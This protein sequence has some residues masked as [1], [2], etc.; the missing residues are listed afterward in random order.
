MV[1]RELINVIGFKI[2][3]AQLRRAEQRVQKMK[4]NMMS[5]GRA[6]TVFVSTPIALMA[7][8]M[9]D[10]AQDVEVLDASLVAFLGT[11]EKA[12]KFRGSIFKFAQE[13]FV[14]I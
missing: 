11:A 14:I 8:S 6:M 10:A 9:M 7:K 1:V 12:S 5:V 4:V 3:E 2:N 13:F